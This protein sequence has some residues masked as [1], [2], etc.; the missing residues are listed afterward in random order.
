MPICCCVLLQMACKMQILLALASLL[1]RPNHVATKSQ[2]WQFDAPTRHQRLCPKVEW[3]ATTSAK[4]AKCRDAITC[5]GKNNKTTKHQQQ[6]QHH[7]EPNLP[8]TINHQHL[9]FQLLRATI[10]VNLVKF[11]WLLLLPLQLHSPSR[12][13]L[14]KQKTTTNND[15]YSHLRKSC[16]L[17]SVCPSR[18][19]W[20]TSVYTHTHVHTCGMAARLAVWQAKTV[21]L[22]LT[23]CRWVL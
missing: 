23:Y 5:N 17:G 11:L 14:D 3:S 16:L 13:K 8:S 19:A 4:L 9:N 18:L 6:H 15:A 12:N 20:Q 2:R 10:K 22:Q 21:Y 1:K 7:L